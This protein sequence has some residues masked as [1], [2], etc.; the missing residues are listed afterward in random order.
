MKLQDLPGSTCVIGIQYFDTQG[1][2]LQQAQ[3]AGEVVKVDEEMGIT[4]RLRHSNPAAGH[5]EFIL[6]P[7]L[8]A[9]FKAPAGHYRNAASGIDITDPQFLVTWNVHRHRDGTAERKQEWWEWIP[10]TE[11]PRVGGRDSPNS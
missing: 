3:Y 10:N 8:A 4:V 5:A 2:L 9:W 6:P 11:P 1:G 7:N